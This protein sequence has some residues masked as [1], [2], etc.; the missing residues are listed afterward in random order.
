MHR[1]PSLPPTH[2][3]PGAVFL[4]P[5]PRRLRERASLRETILI[6]LESTERRALVQAARDAG[7][8]ADLDLTVRSGLDEIGHGLRYLLDL[9]DQYRSGAYEDVEQEILDRLVHA[10]SFEPVETL[11]SSMA[12]SEIQWTTEA[13]LRASFLAHLGGGHRLVLAGLERALMDLIFEQSRVDDLRGPW[14]CWELL[15]IGQVLGF[16]VAVVT[17]AQEESVSDAPV[18]RLVS[19]IVDFLDDLAP[20]TETLDRGLLY[21]EESDPSVEANGIRRSTRPVLAGSFEEG[22]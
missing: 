5:S 21:G 13:A 11:F 17:S 7:A 16:G 22:M 1:I 15:A 12:S 6:H 8:S 9:V 18:V 19:R 3:R 2:P 4:P 10:R 14:L 20:V